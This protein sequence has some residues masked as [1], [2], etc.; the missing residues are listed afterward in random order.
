MQKKNIT[1]ILLAV[2]GVAI[3]T[4]AVYFLFFK[5]GCTDCPT[6]KYFHLGSCSFCQLM[7]PIMDEVKKSYRRKANIVYVDMDRPSGK[8]RARGEGVMGTPTLLFY[9]RHGELVFRLQGAQPRELIE[10]QLD[11][12]IERE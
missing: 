6:L 10:R 2:A 11:N 3:I 1:L 9:D 12:L 8:E 7:D 5:S 4:I